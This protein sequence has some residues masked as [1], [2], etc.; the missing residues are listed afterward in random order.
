MFVVCLM[1]ASMFGTPLVTHSKATASQPEIVAV[2]P[3]PVANEDTGEFVVISFPRRTNLSTWSLS[4]GE[5]IVQLPNATVS[6]RVTFSTAPSLTENLTEQRALQIRNLSLANDGETVTL[7]KRAISS[8][9]A[10]IVDSTTY[11][12]APESELWRPKN[13]SWV[14]LG[15]TDRPVVHVD[16]TTARVFVLPD[17]PAVPTETLQSADERILLA[18]Y[19]FAS[20]R[21][22]RKLVAA[23]RRGV[24]VRVLIDDSPVG[25]ITRQ[26]AIVLDRLSERG[27]HI[28]VI[29]GPHARYSFHHAK[30]AVVDGQ[31]MVL[32]ENWKPAG[33]GG[34]ASRGWGVV[35]RGE[36]A[37]ELAEIFDA[38]STWN[39]TV[40]W[41]QFRRGKSFKSEPPANGS[42][43][44]RFEP[45]TLPVE[46]VSVLSAPDNAEEGVVSLLRS[47]NESIVIQQMAVSGP[48]QPFVQATLA[49][50]RRG[51]HVRVLLSSAW[52]VR[53]DNGHLVRWLNERAEEE[54]LPLQAKL[55]EPNGY[56]KIHA[57]GVI[58]DERHVVVGSLN[59]NNHSARANRELALVLHGTQVGNYYTAVFE[60]DWGESDDRFPVGL[61][62]VVVLG[63]AGAVWLGRTE[64]NVAQSS[65]F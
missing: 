36:S 62:V 26:Q 54:G 6:G 22:A 58:V 29:G 65:E 56:E 25:G 10:T 44:T 64:V 45:K 47:A 2:Y 27:I 34:R 63:A 16:S 18:G 49:A 60:A 43:P 31:A 48:Q 32:T 30:Y 23:E 37:R 20:E 11:V 51:V 41:Q 55:A 9:A 7:R 5:D 1:V 19:S 8:V 46:S 15:A 42:F 61:A 52:Y 17:S 59:W 13:G 33:T 38:D 57:K 14:P 12:D 4:D 39:D 53:E 3:N 28:E 21:I 50:A 40:S 35:V 24:E